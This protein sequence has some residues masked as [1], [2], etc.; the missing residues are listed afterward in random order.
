M[1]T[2]GQSF[3]SSGLPLRCESEQVLDHLLNQGRLILA[4][5][6]DL[7]GHSIRLWFI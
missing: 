1:D 2:H 7:L 4:E 3:D 5:V 6:L